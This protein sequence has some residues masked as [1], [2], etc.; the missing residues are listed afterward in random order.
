MRLPLGWLSVFSPLEAL[1]VTERRPQAEGVRRLVRTLDALGLVV[2]GI[3]AAPAPS[4][5]IVAARVCAIHRI[6]GAD[7]IRLV[8]VDDG[9]HVLRRVVCGAW[10]FEVD[11][12]VPLALPGTT[13]PT[14]VRIEARS[15]RGVRSD[16]MLCSPLEAGLGSDTGGLALLPR[17]LEPG[18]SVAEALGLD[19]EVVVDLAVEPNRPDASGVRGIARDLAARLR[20]P[21]AD[22]EGTLEGEQ[23]DDV[24]VEPG[25]AERL[26]LASVTLDDLTLDPRIAR[27]LALAG[28]RS[29]SP[30]VDATNAVMLETG[31]PSHA[32]DRARL[33][34][35][36]V[37]VRSAR[38]GERLVT[39]DGRERV[40]AG[41]ELVIVDGED[42]VVGLAGIMG[43]R[44]TEVGAQTREVLLEVAAFVRERIAQASRR[45]GLRTEASW[46][47][48]R[49][50]DPSVLEAVARRVGQVVG[51]RTVRRVAEA[52]ELPAP[53]RIRLRTTA[54]LRLSGDPVV[55]EALRPGA[56]LER[57]GFGL[58]PEEDGYVVTVPPWRP[59]VEGAADVV[60]EA[61]RQ[62]GYDAVASASLVGPHRD[63][64]NQRQRR[65]RL[66]SR[67]LSDRGAFEAWSVTLVDPAVESLL[68]SDRE[69]A[70][71]RNPLRPEESVLRTTVLA[72]LLGALD[73]SL[74]RRVEPVRLF[75]LGPVFW[76]LGGEV[77]ERERL[78]LLVG[79]SH[80]G[81]TEAGRWLSDICAR[82]GVALDTVVLRLGQG[83]TGW[84]RLHP[85]RCARL[86]VDDEVV[87]VVGELH[88]AVFRAG[89]VN[90]R[91]RYGYLELDALW[92]WNATSQVELRAPEVHQASELDLSFEVPWDVAA[93]ELAA[94]IDDVLG[95]LVRDVGIFD[96][97]SHDGRRFLGFRLRLAAAE[98]PV[99]DEQLHDAI[100]AARRA[101]E[102]LGARL[103]SAPTS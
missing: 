73:R 68:G 76:R 36:I 7:R 58:E 102:A 42:V 14:G 44:D 55:L 22:L 62:V 32:Y 97:F 39:L 24:T 10:N 29:V 90:P 33:G 30:I 63:G 69:P 99:S 85:G 96:D 57:L 18:Q 67:L 40:L 71:L 78:G 54:V 26:V 60:E 50:V 100:D 59:D 48:E 37:G 31:Q 49:G 27:W 46:R 82:I 2:E 75:E 89:G 11:D 83:G 35:G 12:V 19:D 52:G 25:T 80:D 34:G 88:P 28:V 17:S 77:I 79:A 70:V 84:P 74:R 13:L 72:G 6:E 94:R 92:L 4:S 5:G 101:G 53:R 20:A 64:P 9:A 98:G 93:S 66:V 16:G 41:G 87:G 23:V 15:M 3:E 56:G 43:G 45:S 47:F 91:W 61:L 38:S 8:E 51:C 1:G 21:F 65:E 86:E 95:G 103:R 81:G